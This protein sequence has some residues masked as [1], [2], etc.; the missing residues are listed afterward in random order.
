VADLVI[1][2]KPGC[3]LCGQVKSELAKL[4]GRYPFQLREVNIEEN[5]ELLEE[6]KEKIPVVFVNGRKAF[7]YRRDVNAMV[8][9]VEALL[10]EERKSADGS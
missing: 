10:A 6:Y 7:E 4:R 2:S 5:S 3:H 8:R 9:R 1:Y